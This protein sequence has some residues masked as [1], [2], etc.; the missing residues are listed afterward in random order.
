M[1]DAPY[2][3]SKIIKTKM[4][5]NEHNKKEVTENINE[6]TCSAFD[7][8]NMCAWCKKQR[9]NHPLSDECNEDECMICGENDCEYGD[10]LHYHHDGCPSCVDEEY[11]G[12]I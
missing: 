7:W 1:K 10:P 4:E 2:D 3:L 8:A 9:E 11:R 6:C 12:V 5:G